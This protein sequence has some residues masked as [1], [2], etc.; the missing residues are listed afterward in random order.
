MEIKKEDFSTTQGFVALYDILGY[1]Q[2]VEENDLLKVVAVHEKM[3]EM[4]KNNT[5]GYVYRL[6]KPIITVYNYADTFLI[7]TN[8]MSDTGFKALLVGCHFMFIAAIKYGL[9]IRGATA[10]GEFY[11][12]ENL[13]TGKP[14]IEAYKKERKQD[15]IGCWITKECLDKI[16]E[17]A[18]TKFIN[19]RKIVKYPIPFKEGK[20][21]EVYAFNWL[22]NIFIQGNS[23]NQ[24]YL[25][26]KSFLQK[27]NSHSWRE[28]RKHKNTKE[29]IHFVLNLNH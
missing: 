6:G 10:C 27:K 21:E 13:I 15:W 29:F 7:Y 3:K 23:I 14:I 11:I 2:L 18:R 4:M 19:E 28:E 26:T 1:S 12:S 8:E 24:N 9:P 20:V 17:D 25:E 16:T 22:D 5:E